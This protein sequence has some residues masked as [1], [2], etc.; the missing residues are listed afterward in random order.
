MP[1]G[2]LVVGAAAAGAGAAGVAA[3][4]GVG[5]TTVVVEIRDGVVIRLVLG[6]IGWRPELAGGWD[7]GAAWAARAFSSSAR[8]TFKPLER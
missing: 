1:A 5:D 2:L 6:A 4:T 8:E 3:G 7:C